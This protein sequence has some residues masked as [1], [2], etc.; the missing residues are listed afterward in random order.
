MH[1]IIKK[2]GYEGKIQGLKG[3]PN[4][5]AIEMVEKF[6]FELPFGHLHRDREFQKYDMVGFQLGRPDD[7]VSESE[8]KD[9]KPKVINEIHIG[10]SQKN[11]SYTIFGQDYIDLLREIFEGRDEISW[12]LTSPRLRRNETFVGALPLLLDILQEGWGA[13]YEF[14]LASADLKWAVDYNH[15]K[16][17]VIVGNLEVNRAQNLMEG[18]KWN[19]K[20]L[21]SNFYP[22]SKK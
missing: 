21:N 20:V 6:L 9:R 11:R 17:M 5:K 22:K 18:R 13:P 19:S 14:T 1:H 3:A 8:K 7:H 4:E 10:K 15:H 12:L 16:S 2:L